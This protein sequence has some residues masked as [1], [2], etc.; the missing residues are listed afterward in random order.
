MEKSGIL[1][2]FLW[3]SCGFLV[4]NADLSVDNSVDF[5]VEN[6]VISTGGATIIAS[7]W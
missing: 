6:L 1:V 3:I 2:D 5:I 4:E 7:R